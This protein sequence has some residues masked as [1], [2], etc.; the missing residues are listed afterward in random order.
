MIDNNHNMVYC[1][2]RELYLVDMAIRLLELM[3]VIFELK[4]VLLRTTKTFYPQKLTFQKIGKVFFYHAQ[5][6]TLA[7]ISDGIVA[8]S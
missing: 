3:S 8:L 1:S 6:N 4:I 2:K 7:L 5:V